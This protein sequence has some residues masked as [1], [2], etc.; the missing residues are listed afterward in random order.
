MQIPFLLGREHM[1]WRQVLNISRHTR[2]TL[3]FSLPPS[4]SRS[5]FLPAPPF[6]LQGPIPVL[7]TGAHA[8]RLPGPSHPTAPTLS[9]RPQRLV[10]PSWRKLRHPIEK[11]KERYVSDLLR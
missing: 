6:T 7:F 9:N 2:L 10:G 4:P 5:R 1:M 8:S 11:K 3:A